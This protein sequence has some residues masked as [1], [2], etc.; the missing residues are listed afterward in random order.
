MKTAA[1]VKPLLGS[2][3]SLYGLVIVDLINIIMTKSTLPFLETMITYACNLSCKGCTN[4]SDYNM[5]GSVT[6]S[7][8]KQWL[9]K[10]LSVFDIPDFGLIGGEPMLNPEVKQWIYGCRD[11]MPNSQIRFTTNAV[12]FLKNAEV[13][14]WCVDIGN[15]VFKFSVHEDAEY[16]KESID[17]VFSR[18][19]WKP[20]TEF[21]INR[22]EGLN[23]TK[24]QINSPTKFV[25]S[26]LGEYGNMS[27]H[28]ND[29]IES[30]DLC[31]QK[32]CPLLLGGKIYKCSSV[33]LLDRVL[34]DWGQ[35]I[36]TEWQPYVT[37][38]QPLTLDSNQEQ[39]DQFLNNFGK[40][41]YTCAMCPSAKDVNSIVDHKS[42]VS[43]KKQWIALHLKK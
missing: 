26:F 12:N 19:H 3:Y 32:T 36:S 13:L 10:W 6:W 33:A 4:Y 40:P 18:Y 37:D 17:Y 34:T 29:P 2:I 15:C 7:E 41:Y 38:Y 22:W 1:I 8:G 31:V 16:V 27:P 42:T 39:I 30:F 28:N 14:D 43:T 11:L 23:R 24:F 9:E 5:K 25:K 20:V 21:G 35:S